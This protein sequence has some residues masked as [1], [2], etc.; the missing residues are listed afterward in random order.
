M[1]K[2]IKTLRERLSERLSRAFTRKS[3]QGNYDMNILNDEMAKGLRDKEETIR[4]TLTAP[5]FDPRAEP[6]FEK[7]QRQAQRHKGQAQRRKGQVCDR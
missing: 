3:R 5:D 7:A 1:S 6:G 2:P 4:E